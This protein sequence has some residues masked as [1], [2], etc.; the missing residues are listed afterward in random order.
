LYVLDII[1]KNGYTPEF[2]GIEN[3]KD[4]VIHPQKWLENFDY[5]N[6]KVMVIGSG[7]TAVT[8]VPKMAEKTAKITMLQRSPTY[9]GTFPN[10]DKVAIFLKKIL[11]KKTAHRAIQFKNILVQVI[12]FN[13]L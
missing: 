10:K 7:A 3:F 13:A 12:F 9:V 4:E 5:S 11:P 8:I 1:L 2:K 6:K